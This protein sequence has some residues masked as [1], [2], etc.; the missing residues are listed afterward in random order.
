[1]THISEVLAS[2]SREA[3]TQS[4]KNSEPVPWHI[5]VPLSVEL[6]LEEKKE[7]L[8]KSLGISSW[9]NTFESFRP[10]PG[11]EEA[12]AAFKALAEGTANIPML[13]CY[14]G[15]G[16]GKTHLAEAAVIAL[17]QRG[18]F[19]RV[20]TMARM[21]RALKQC[22]R[23][24]AQTAYD[25]LI[26]RYC[27]CGYLILDDVGMGGSGSEWEFGQLEEIV[28]ARYRE[29]LFTIMATNLDLKDLPERI[30]S[31]FQDPLIGT[32]VLNEG[33]DYRISRKSV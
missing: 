29:R 33:A 20:M 7:R 3:S 18:I 2:L 16:N 12:L 30:V 13:L 15:V 24:D 25:E 26:E 9:N 1:M 27:R 31:R 28:V 11:T 22:M 32:V 5:Y 6:T 21:M 23:P 10:V 8:R 19:S 4:Q 17:N 14:G